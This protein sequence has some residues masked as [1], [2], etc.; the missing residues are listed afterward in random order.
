MYGNEHKG[1]IS[2]CLMEYIKQGQ[3]CVITVYKYRRAS[4]I[5]SNRNMV[6]K[7]QRLLVYS[8][9]GRICLVCFLMRR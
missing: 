6:N 5:S 8:G 2:G 9:Q 7:K 3:Y 4:G 1:R